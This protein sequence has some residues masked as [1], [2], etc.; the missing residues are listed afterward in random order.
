M[1]AASRPEAAARAGVQRAPSAH[2]RDPRSDD[3][4]EVARRADHPGLG[5]DVEQDDVRGLP[6]VEPGLGDDH[7]PRQHAKPDPED[8]PLEEDPHRALGERDA[9]LDGSRLRGDRPGH[10][11]PCGDGRRERDDQRGADEER[12]TRGK[13]QAPDCGPVANQRQHRERDNDADR[14]RD[15]RRP[16][17]GQEERHDADGEDD[18]A[19]ARPA[20]RDAPRPSRG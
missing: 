9:L 16:R 2:Q 18:P 4:G 14:V 7:R 17:E 6:L 15:P 13:E 10:V 3:Q 20:T 12:R 8:R 11:D 5:S 1:T 19:R